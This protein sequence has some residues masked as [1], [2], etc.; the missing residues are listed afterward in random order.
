MKPKEIEP[1]VN[2]LLLTRRRKASHHPTRLLGRQQLERKE[3]D[4]ESSKRHATLRSIHFERR[5]FFLPFFDPPYSI[6][7]FAILVVYSPWEFNLLA[8][9]CQMLLLS[10]F[11]LYRHPGDYRTL[12]SLSLF[13]LVA[14]HV[15]FVC[16]HS[17]GLYPTAYRIKGPFP[18]LPPPLLLL[19]SVDLFVN[20]SFFYSYS[21]RAPSSSSLLARYFD[22]ILH[23]IIGSI[24][25][26]CSSNSSSSSSS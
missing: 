17:L 10:P 1:Y 8:G 9:N 11:A 23:N 3:K 16:L 25:L 15:H 12:L 20:V 26:Y 21:T 22:Q 19:M 18:P 5:I 2:W 24:L 6:Y 13:P 4:D 7:C 14:H